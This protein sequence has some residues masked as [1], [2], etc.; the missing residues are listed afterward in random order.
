MPEG[1]PFFADEPILRIVA[2]LAQ[3]QLVETRVVAL[4]HF[5]S[6]IASKAA[7]CALAAPG[8]LQEYA[9]V[10]RRKRSDGKRTWPGRKQVFRRLREGKRLAPAAALSELRK[11]TLAGLETL[12]EGLR[13]LGQ[14]AAPYTVE[15]TLALRAL[16]D[17]VDRRQA[18]VVEAD[19]IS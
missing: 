11:R 13:D 3:A 2:P 8:N 1:T 4:L 12:P 15:V 5:S 6:L 19:R 16:A 14:A 9:G 10:A 7:R 18:A 17:A